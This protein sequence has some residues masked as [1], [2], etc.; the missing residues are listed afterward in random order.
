MGTQPAFAG[1]T[2]FPLTFTKAGTYPYICILY[3][4]QSMAGVIEV[5]TT[6]GAGTIR[7]PDTGDAGLVSGAGTAHPTGSR[8]RLSPWWSRR[9]R[10]AAGSSVEALSLTTPGRV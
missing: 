8:A 4:S 3:V 5:G 6:G 10:G 2:R 1:G 9:H 7:A